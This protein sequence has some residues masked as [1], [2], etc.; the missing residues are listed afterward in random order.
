[1]TVDLQLLGRAKVQQEM[2]E[3]AVAHADALCNVDRAQ[4]DTLL[5]E[6]KNGLRMVFC[7]F[8][9]RHADCASLGC[10]YRAAYPERRRIATN[11]SNSLRA[12]GQNG[13]DDAEDWVYN[14]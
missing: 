7:R 4:P 1:M 14:D 8:M 5:A 3:Q 6:Q 10:I 12:T 2:L 9:D 11:C 13:F